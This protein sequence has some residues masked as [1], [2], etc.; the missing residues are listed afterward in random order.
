MFA[1]IKT[2]VIISSILL[3]LF[4]TAI[5]AYILFTQLKENFRQRSIYMLNS[6]TEMLKYGLF[7]EMMKGDEKNIQKVIDDLGKLRGV[8]HIRVFSE[9]GTILYTSEYSEKNRNLADIAPHHVSLI[10][11]HKRKI[12]LVNEE[13]IYSVTEPI[14]NEAPCQNCHNQTDN[15]AYL[16]IDSD[17]TSPENIFYTGIAIIPYL[18]VIILVILSIGLILIFNHFINTPLKHLIAGLE[19][20]E[21]GNL[22]FSLPVKKNDEISRVFN[23]FNS[24]V[25]KLKDSKEKIDEMHLEELQRVNRLKTIGELTS[26]MAHEINNHSAIIMSRSDFLKLEANKNNVLK[27][28]DE[29]FN[30]IL[31]RLKKITNIT[32]S[33]LRHSKKHR[34]NF[35]MVD[36]QNIVHRGITILSPLV[37]KRNIDINFKNNAKNTFIFADDIQIEQALLNLIKNSVEAMHSGGLISI[38][39]NQNLGKLEL[40]IT[41]NGSGIN[42]DIKEHIFSPFFTSKSEKEGTGLGLYIAKSICKNNSVDINFKSV[43][44]KGTTFTLTFNIPD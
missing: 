26:Q 39:L 43:Q 2:K 30:V 40:N 37:K 12:H 29:D 19:N 35:A 1:K 9:D 20:V 27:K 15:I 18:A 8:E 13:G 5:P 11:I 25:S 33:I 24:M 16:D 6:S 34:T 14:K 23:H 4:G 28:Y 38:E 3:I 21:K 22:D 41:D 36:L 10:G 32:G 31:D 42:D 7:T 17:F 44:G